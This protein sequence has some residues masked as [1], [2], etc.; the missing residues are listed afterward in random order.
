MTDDQRERL[1]TLTPDD[2][3]LV[4]GR[5][6]LGQGKAITDPERW[7]ACARAGNASPGDVDAVFAALDR[8]R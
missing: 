8:A 3:P 4:D 5:L 2:L 7:I 1:R 6:P